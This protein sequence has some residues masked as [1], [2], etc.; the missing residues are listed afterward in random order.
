MAY[1]HERNYGCRISA[2]YTYRGLRTIV[3]ENE[4][5][6]ISVLADKGTDIFEFLYKPADVDFLWRSPLGVR[7]P[8][9]NVPTISARNGS[10]LD[11]FEGG[12]QECLPNGGWASTY[13]GANLGLHGEIANIPWQYSILEDSPE[14]IE[15]KFWVRTYR[16]P[17]Y[18]EKF[19]SLE[20]NSPILHIKEK[21]INEG[22][23]EMDLMWGYHP[24]FGPP[25]LSEH[26]RVDV[27]ARKVEVCSECAP[28]S[29]LKPGEKFSWPNGKGKNGKAV[30][31]SRIPPASIKAADMVYLLDL[32]EGWYAIT[33]TQKKVGF[34]LHW[35]KEIF[36]YLWYWQDY[37]G[38]FGYPL[39]G[40][41]YV[42]ALEPFTSY[43][44]FGLAEAI[45]RGTQMK[46]AAGKSVLVELKAVA[47][48][49]I[50]RVKGITE[51]G[52]I[53]SR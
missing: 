36:P 1:I 52:E 15:V 37:Q 5:L 44:R 32:K 38:E 22:E 33:N 35:P 30:D 50:E 40:R 31:L 6:R 24:A 7:N 48:E 49:G 45:K 26:C 42:V 25:F 14:R 17:F 34:G 12:W 20:G 51:Q 43:P 8:S 53:H 13:K 2:D 3:I 46:L 19:L 27:P 18:L 16:T 23:E 21:L 28:N 41:T 47:Y 29:R 11:Y 39:Y 10:F 4:K 9:L